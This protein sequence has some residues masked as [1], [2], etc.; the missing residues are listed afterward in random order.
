VGTLED[1]VVYFQ[2]T[3]DPSNGLSRVCGIDEWRAYSDDGS[4]LDLALCAGRRARL[5]ICGP[6]A[7][8]AR[9]WG[10]IKALFE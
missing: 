4:W 7:V 5:Q 6:T 2:F 9:T 1:W 8:E 3:A 10:A